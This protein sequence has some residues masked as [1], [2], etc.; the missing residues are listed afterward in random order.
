M[1]TAALTLALTAAC[2]VSIGAAQAATFVIIDDDPPNVGLNDL[3]PVAPVGGNPGTTLGEQ[4]R[5]AIQIAANIW[6][7]KLASPLPIRVLAS[8]TSLG[9]G[10]IGAGGAQGWVKDFPNAPRANTYYAMALANALSGHDYATSERY[11]TSIVILLNT[12][13]GTP[14]CFAGESF[15]LGLDGVFDHDT[16]EDLVSLTL[17][18]IGHGLGF[19]STV[20]VDGSFV[21]SAPDIF[22]TFV[23]DDTLALHLSA[24]SNAQRL[25]ALCNAGHVTFDGP[26]VRAQET[27]LT[28]GRGALTA[29]PLLYTPLTCSGASH[30]D[31]S[32]VPDQL[33]EP[34]LSPLITHNV[35]VPADLTTS[36]L[37]D[38]G[39]QPGVNTCYALT[40]N[41]VPVDDGGTITI[42]SPPTCAIGTTPGFAPWSDVVLTAHPPVGYALASWSVTG[43]ATLSSST[44]NPVT[45]EI[46]GTASVTAHLVAQSGTVTELLVDGGFE[47]ASATGNSAPGWAMLPAS[48]DTI[49]RKGDGVDHNGDVS[50]AMTKSDT[51]VQVVSI[52]A[53][54][55]FAGLSFWLN[56]TTQ[57]PGNRAFDYLDVTDGGW[58][59]S[60]PTL[61]EFTNVDAT[62]SGNTAG[63]YF[64]VGPIDVTASKGSSLDLFFQVFSDVTL[65]TTFRIDDVSLQ[66]LQPACTTFTLSPPSV[67]TRYI[68]GSQTVSIAGLPA[69]CVGGSWSAAGNGSWLSVFPTAGVESGSVTVSWTQNTSFARSSTIVIAGASFTVSQGPLP[70]VAPELTATGTSS[71]TV[72]LRWPRVAAASS[73][74]VYR[75]G[76]A[77]MEP[78]YI[79]EVLARACVFVGCAMNDTGLQPESAYIY[80]VRPVDQ[81]GDAGPTS[82]LD[83]ATTFVFTDDPIVPGVTRVKAT[84]INEIQGAINAMRRLAGASGVSLTAISQGSLIIADDFMKMRSPLQKTRELL[85]LAMVTFGRTLQPA[86][87]IK[88]ADLEELRSGVK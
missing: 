44:S 40:T 12:D 57:D 35:D 51:V 72:E 43:P 10:P 22:S 28:A 60:R 87:T 84:H 75:R 62:R 86:M 69:G 54:A 4:R 70:L 37:L 17:H 42:E 20:L 58:T 61:A 34:A 45:V 21:D 48:G 83:L 68:A 6:G 79:G 41:A 81:Y 82:A 36:A 65:T 16:Q 38:L 47:Q 23:Y 78:V 73:Y 63:R 24:M 8:F 74:N 71:T 32:C 77:S 49:V 88:A 39:W 59:P 33:M 55:I 50:V 13:Y 85:E 29:D 31:L 30:L 18:E 25:S 76:P 27:I 66:V 15:Y 56:V 80:S 9:C 19:E 11:D 1:R 53:N 2:M 14:T 46:G 5:N 7:N 67:S 3:T 26:H 64:K 52:P